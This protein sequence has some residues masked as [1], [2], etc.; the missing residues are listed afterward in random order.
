[1]TGVQTCALPIWVLCNLWLARFSDQAEQ[2]QRGDGSLSHETLFN[3]GVYASLGIGQALGIALGSIIMSF[4]M[5]HAG[6]VLHEKMLKHVLHARMAWFDIT[7]LGRIVNRFG[8]DID[9]LDSRIPGCFANF[10]SYLLQ[11]LVILSI[12]VVIIPWVGPVYAGILIF[13]FF[14]LRYYVSTSRQLKRLELTTKSPIYSHFQ[15]S[16]QGASSIRAYHCVDRFLDESQRRVDTNISTYYP[17]IISNRWLAVRL[18]LVGNLIVFFSA[19]SAVL[20]RSSE[21]VTAGLAGLSISYAMQVTQTLNWAV[22]MT[23]E[24]ETN[25]VSVERIKDYCESPETEPS[26]ETPKELNLSEKWPEKGEIRFE[27]LAMRYRPHLDLVLKGVT[28][29]LQPREKI[30]IIGRT[31]AG[32]SSLTLALF[33]ICEPSSGRIIIDDVDI[34]RLGIRDL[35]SR[36][37][38]VPQDPVLFSGT[39]RVNLDPFD[40]YSDSDIWTALELT[41]LRDFVE[42]LPDKLEH[43]I[44]EGGQNLSVGQRQLICLTRALLRQSRILILDEAAASVDIETDHLIQST[45]RDQFRDCTV[46]TIAH[47]LHSVLESDR[48]LVFSEGRVTEFDSPQNLFAQ[49]N[50][51]FRS[52]A[53]DAGIN[54]LQPAAAAGNSNNGKEKTN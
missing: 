8:K 31:G 27:N 35:R 44:S 42:T 11:S 34:A 45:I 5:I 32:K 3:L 49:P 23:S 13:H 33:R 36:L 17:S 16:V 51:L 6:R 41:H 14:T 22:R 29:H 12:P 37:T 9:C 1:M 21:H 25:I 19:L 40:Q 15:E 38:I 43:K 52:L 53:L 48:L 10:I 47:R 4:G 24:L 50:S 30:G 28:A 39:L 7:P 2:I 26:L 20:F 46:L 18:E 54:S